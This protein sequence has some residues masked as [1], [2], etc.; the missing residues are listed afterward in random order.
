MFRKIWLAITNSN[1]NWV[2]LVYSI[3]C[4]ILIFT[5][6]AFGQSTEYA[7]SEGDILFISVWGD[8]SLS[9]TVTVGP[10]GTVLLPPPIGSVYVDQ[11]TAD[12]I[13]DLVTNKLSIYV[14]QPP[15]VSVSI[16]SFQGFVVHL[17]GQVR[18]PSFYR[19]PEGTSLQEAITQA[20]GLTE[21]ADPSSIM[22]IRKNDEA[23]ERQQIDFT[24]FTKETDMGSNPIL[25]N[26]DIIVIPGISIDEKANQ[27]VTVLGEVRMPGTYPIEI[28]MSI[29]DVLALAGGILPT[30]DLKEVIIVDRSKKGSEAYRKVDIENIFSGSP[31]DEIPTIFP[32]DTVIIPR[33][34]LFEEDSFSVNV[35]GQV[36]K[37]GAYPITKGMRLI[38]AIFLAD[39]FA[40][41]ASI[42]DITLVRVGTDNS[43]VSSYSLKEYLVSGNMNANPLLQERDTI[44]VPVIDSSRIISPVQMAFSPSIS[45][46]VIGEVMKPGV[47]QLPV[48]S[49]LLHALTQAGGPSKDSDLERAMVVRGE[50][51]G[52]DKRTLIN[53]EEVLTEGKLELLPIM[54][55]GDVVLIPKE[56]EKREIWRAIMTGIRD[57]SL[58]L[59]LIYY[60]QRIN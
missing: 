17:L 21:M 3:P 53:L 8:E 23:T 16:R 6:A 51:S 5:I 11:L 44:I 15:V 4:L 47:Y 31:Q 7:V 26:G 43:V 2:R 56:R 33:V 45:I 32:G 14:K 42:D 38:D 49:N 10:D 48:D 13:A 55:S 30:S 36:V 60:V 27:S 29:L 35:T 20:G 37:P 12:E 19:I 24:R 34:T 18:S 52:D 1:K 54:G 40:A 57:V 28:P 46:S 58:I 41:E 22:L 50:S 39:G 9:G 25:K 59:G